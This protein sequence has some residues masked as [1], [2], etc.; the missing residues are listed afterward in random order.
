MDKALN[1]NAYVDKLTEQQAHELLLAL[2]QKFSVQSFVET[3]DS[4]YVAFPCPVCEP[5]RYKKEGWE[6]IH[7]I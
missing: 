5:D 3:H 4:S 1:A 6:G 2:N 7:Y